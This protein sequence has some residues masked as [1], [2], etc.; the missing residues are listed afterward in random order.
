NADPA[1]RRQRTRDAITLMLLGASRSQPVCLVV[2]DLHWI[3]PETQEVLDHLVS[4]LTAARLLLLVT[5][6]LE[7]GHSWDAKS[8]Y[9]PL[10]VDALPAES[11]TVLLDAVLGSDPGLAPLK[12]LLAGQGNPFFLEETVRMLVDTNTLAG[13]SGRYRLAHPVE[14]IAVPPTVQA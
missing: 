2:E 9:H 7:Y 10:T 3:D 1:Q 8:V 11:V 6:R 13:D 12:R 5:Y 4:G 14:A